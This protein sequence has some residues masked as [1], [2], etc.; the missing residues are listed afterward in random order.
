M[1]VIRDTALFVF[2]LFVIF[3][4]V[5][6]LGTHPA[7]AVGDFFQAA[8]HYAGM[9]I[10]HPVLRD[11]VIYGVITGIGG[12]FVYIP[13]IMGMFLMANLLV[14]ANLH[15]RIGRLLHP[16]LQRAGLAGVSAVPM[17]FCFGCTVN[18]MQCAS[19]ITEPGVRFRT[20]CITP[21]MS[22][23]SKVYV[24][25]LLIAAVFPLSRR[26]PVL[27]LLY[28]SG[29]VVALLTA[30]LMKKLSLLPAEEAVTDEQNVH[31]NST[32]DTM[33]MPRVRIPAIGSAVAG[34]LRD[35]WMFI[36]TA[37]V[38]IVIATIIIW[39]LS[40]VPG[41]PQDTY[42]AMQQRARQQGE[43]LPPR[44]TL[45]LHSSYL[46]RVG[47]FVQPL[48]APL[49]FDWRTTVA[50]GAGFT[51]RGAIIA[52]LNTFYGI[53]GGPEKKAVLAQA[54]RE[55]AFY[56][57][58]TA[59]SFMVFVLLSGSCLAGITMFFNYVSSWRVTALFV[60]YPLVVAWIAAAIS[61]QVVSLIRGP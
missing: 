11:F 35:T 47:A 20:L 3:E 27:V 57:S 7:E 58:A 46:A 18:G 56:D 43:R 26:A 12:L 32:A 53:Q 51:G 5:F 31:R 9:H 16:L 44:R 25:I 38:V 21:F 8:V 19:R 6:F 49:G 40:S 61:Y 33:M 37:G 30:V 60:A 34:T 41:I 14:S 42:A 55:S 15:Y 29:L 50:V 54:L 48:F 10:A 45:A 28:V 23:G 2:A 59:V 13:N 24:Y 1:S 22:C 4:V 36:R 52:T 17:T 39:A